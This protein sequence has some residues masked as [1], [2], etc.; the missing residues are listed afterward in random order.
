MS[1]PTPEDRTNITVRVL[2]QAICEGRNETSLRGKSGR[3]GLSF[4]AWQDIAR[5]EIA[6]AIRN[7]EAEV[8]KHRGTG[9]RIA[10]TIAAC[11]VTVGF[12]GAAVS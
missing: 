5:V 7:T 11:L 3:P 1:A 9:N 2:E 12:W 4:Y 10:M 6:N 8:R